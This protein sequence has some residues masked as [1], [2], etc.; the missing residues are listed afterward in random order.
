MLNIANMPIKSKLLALIVMPLLGLVYFSGNTLHDRYTTQSEMVKIENLSHIAESI[1]AVVHEMQKERGMSAGFLGS[2]GKKFA[3]ELPEQRRLTDKK[4]QVLKREFDDL[5]LADYE[6]SLA[7]SKQSFYQSMSKL[8]NLRTRVTS[9]QAPLPEVL[10][11]YTQTIAIGIDTIASMQHLTHDGDI[12]TLLSAYVNL[13]QVK[14]NSGIERAVLSNTFAADTFAPGIYNKF[15]SLTSAQNTLIKSFN[16]IASSSSKQALQT[17]LNNEA[18]KSVDEMRATAIKFAQTGGFGVDASVWFK[19]ITQKINELHTLETTLAKGIQ[20]QT[21]AKASAAKSTFYFYSL[22]LLIL[23]LTIVWLT[24]RIIA[25]IIEPA[26]KLRN[27]MQSVVAKGDFAQTADVNQADEIGQMAQAFNQLLSS[28]S[29]ALNQANLVV[30]A[31]AKGQF[32]KRITADFH[33]DLNKLKEGVNGSAESVSFTMNQLK[34]VMDA[35]SNGDFSV[36]LD[37][38]VEE[39]FRQTVQN[40]LNSMKS[41]MDEVN[42]TMEHAANGNF[43]VTIQTDARGELKRLKDSV[44]T[45]VAEIAFALTAINEVV[46]AQAQGD[47]T[48]KVAEGALKGQL[49]DLKNA[50][51]YANAKVVEVVDIATEASAVVSGAAQEVSQ[52]SMDLSHR[53]QEQAAA[54]EQTSATMEEMN[55]QIQSTSQNAIHATEEA[56]K[57][58]KNASSGVGVMQETIESMNKI[59]ESSHKIAEI[60]TLIDGIAFQTNLLALNAAVEAARAGDHGRGFAVV[61]GE[62]RNLAQKSADAAKDIKH[63]IDETVERVNQGSALATESGKVL[64]DINISINSV[65]QMIGEIATASHEQAEGIR[66]VHQA[67]TQIDNVTQ[68]NAALVEETSAAS[69]SLS[70]QSDILLKEISFFKTGIAHNNSTNKRPGLVKK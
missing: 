13:L 18:A 16:L 19:T 14:E 49:H 22:L 4:Y 67:I 36:Q 56:Q 17:V 27:I 23:G 32:D 70:E 15:I 34:I 7:Q 64:S 43:D 24:I 57:A 50:M 66:Q 5:N 35:L 12:I 37:K 2:K 62:V 31:V 1:G 52:G 6:P 39:S 59:Q 61:A 28:T 30:G 44:N 60:V 26:N 68:Q 9:L 55:S 48:H 53:V 25:G 29:Q 41:V 63:L 54:L 33:G 3:T 42:T 21:A 11:F 45:S 38:S 65:T 51:N 47:L 10:G 40:A 69:E 20:H 8:A 46:Q 58:Q